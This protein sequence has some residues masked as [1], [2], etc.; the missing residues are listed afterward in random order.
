MGDAGFGVGAFFGAEDD[1]GAAA[2]A[3]EAADDGGVVGEG[4][5]AG[6]RGEIG[7]QALDVELGLGALGVSGDLGFLPGG[8]LGVGGAELTVGLFRQFGDFLG[9]V[10]AIGFGHF[11]KLFDF[12]F[13]LGNRFFEFEEVAHERRFS[14]CSIAG[15]PPLPGGGM[16][17]R[18]PTLPARG[19]FHF[20]VMVRNRGIG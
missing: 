17:L 20:A 1:D 10:D 4:A 12:A 8:E 6:E 11:P 5:I 2:E 13:E 3:A 7:D 18:Y 9:D 19:A 14:T 16:N 15:Q